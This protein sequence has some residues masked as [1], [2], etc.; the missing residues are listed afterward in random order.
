MRLGG[1]GRL[2]APEDRLRWIH[3]V[4][5]VL[6]KYGMGWTMWDYAGGF[7]VAVSMEMGRRVADEGTLRALGLAK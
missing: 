5:T 4:R 2:R 7:S 3:D 6:E 1:C